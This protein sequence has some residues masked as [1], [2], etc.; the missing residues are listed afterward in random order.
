MPMLIR[1]GYIR[2]IRLQLN[3][4]VGNKTPV[5]LNAQRTVEDDTECYVWLFFVTIERSNFERDLLSARRRADELSEIS[6]NNERFIRTVTDSLPSMIAYW[7]RNLICQFANSEYVNWFGL[8]PSKVVG[9]HI[10][11]LLGAHIFNL[12]FPPIQRALAGEVQEFERE[13]TRPDGRIGYLLANYIPD[14]DTT[15]AVKGFFALVTNISA[16]KEADAAIRL[17]AS[18]FDATSEGIVVT[19][20][21]SMI[22]SINKGF[23]KLTGYSANDLIGKNV[24]ALHSSSQDPEFLKSLYEELSVTEKWK[25]DVWCRRKDHSTFLGRLSISVIRND[26]TEVTKYV[27]VFD[28][29]TK[30]WD[31]EQMVYQMA[32]HDSLTSLPNRLLL[33]ERLGRLISMAAR[34]ERQ[35]ALLF[36]DLDGFK[37]IN[38]I[39]GHDVGDRVL[40]AVA[41][42]LASQLRQSDTVARLGGDEFVILLDQPDSR[43]SILYIASRLIALVNEPIFDQENVAHVGTSIGISIFKN[44]GQSAEQLLKLA[45]EAMYKAKKN[46]KNNYVFSDDS[47]VPL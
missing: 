19:D 2:E 38:D 4:A 46:G 9:M 29:I 15:G 37:L 12:N 18:V 23:T 13:I 8:E 20:A 33:M 14:R 47:H 45:D 10:A 7:D 26:A 39:H 41:I 22:L 32:F 24:H 44:N 27:V 11:D 3:D 17:A 35:I 5:Y 34:E 25:G 36:L 43:E 30:Q 40:Q 31:R 16:V 21:N 1:E 6:A 28:D 42:R